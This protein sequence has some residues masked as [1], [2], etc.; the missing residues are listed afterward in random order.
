MPNDY[1]G[2]NGA[3]KMGLGIVA[4]GGIALY[5]RNRRNRVNHSTRVAA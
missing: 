2:P 4:I 3:I 1:V 5:I